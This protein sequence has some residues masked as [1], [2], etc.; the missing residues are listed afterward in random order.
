[1]YNSAR[2]GTFQP[3]TRTLATTNCSPS[4]CECCLAIQA[5]Q[6]TITQYSC[7][8]TAPVCSHIRALRLGLALL[9]CLYCFHG[10]LANC[11][12][13]KLL[14]ACHSLVQQ[15]T[16]TRRVAAYSR[17][18]WVSTAGS[19]H[20]QALHEQALH[21]KSSDHGQSNSSLSKTLKN[22]CWLDG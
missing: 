14:L 5:E 22:V 18:R 4:W 20:D 9:G 11:T 19:L 17:V 13:L 7:R 6:S 10:G 1:M 3:R 21:E 16:Q 2:F 8:S 15:Q 12:L